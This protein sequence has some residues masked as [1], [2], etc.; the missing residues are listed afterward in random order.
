MTSLPPDGISL[1]NSASLQEGAGQVNN[2][3]C[4]PVECILEVSNVQVSNCEMNKAMVSFDVDWKNAQNDQL[5][6]VSLAGFMDTISMVGQTMPYSLTIEVDATGMEEEYS[7]RFIDSDDCIMTGTVSLPGNCVEGYSLIKNFNSINSNTDGS[8][9]VSYNVL[10][11]NTGGVTGDYNLFDAP[12]FDT[13]ITINSAEFKLSTDATFSGLSPNESQWT[14]ATDKVLAG[15]SIDEYIVNVNFTIDLTDGVQGDDQLAVC[16]ANGGTPKPG[17]ALYNEARLDIDDDQVIDIY[18]H[19]CGDVDLFDLALR[20]TI[21]GPS[22]YLVGSVI[23]FEIEIFNQGY[24]AANNI[25]IS[26]FIPCGFSFDPLMNMGWS[27]SG[28][29]AT[30]TMNTILNPGDSRSIHIRL[31]LQECN[32]SNAFVN[33]AEIS[34]AKESDGSPSNDVDSTPDDNPNNDL[35]IDDEINSANDEDDHDIASVSLYDIAL[36]K[37][38][39]NDGPFTVGDLV[40]FKIEVFNQGV[41]AAQNV[42]VSDYIPCGLVFE[43]GV[44]PGW[45]LSGST[46]SRTITNTLLSGESRFVEIKLRVKACDTVD[47]Y[48]NEA[49]ISAAQDINGNPGQDADSTPDAL[50]GNDGTPVNDAVLDASDEDDHDPE[51]VE[52]FDLAIRKTI[53]TSGP[54]SFGEDLTFAM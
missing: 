46:A 23:D 48:L 38:I 54:Y 4:M 3:I 9:T 24:V 19:A 13:D 40:N 42:T 17:E 2:T 39:T 29:I 10:V 34:S 5:L 35:L 30:Y 43:S 20:K 45:T 32:A 25:E 1:C 15:G 11:E 26:D 47:A 51:M 36:R 33:H 50:Q 6:E 44:N 14:L 12:S 41:D 49:E 21:A 18:D 22:D 8:F 52:I 31:K 16:G 27:K 28:S 37:T 7:I 53:T